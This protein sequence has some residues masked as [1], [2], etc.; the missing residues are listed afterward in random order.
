ML[1]KNKGNAESGAA[2]QDPDPSQAEAPARRAAPVSVAGPNTLGVGGEDDTHSPGAS[3]SASEAGYLAAAQ[4]ILVIPRLFGRL[5]PPEVSR[6]ALT[7]ISED[8][9]DVPAQYVRDNVR[10]HGEWY[11]VDPCVSYVPRI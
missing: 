7:A 8:Y 9:V 2:F 10:L 6:D 3:V 1:S 5:I 11:V 4:N